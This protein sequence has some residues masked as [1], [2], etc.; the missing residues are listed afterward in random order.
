MFWTPPFRPSTPCTKR[1]PFDF[2]ISLGDACN[3]TQYNE[4]R[5]YLD[6]IDGKVI[7]PSSGANLGAT[8]VDYQK[9][10]KAAGLNPAIPWYQAMGNH[11]H[12]FIGSV[13]VDADPSLQLRQSYTSNKIW[14]AGDVVKPNSGNFPCIFDTTASIKEQTFYMGVLDGS[15]PYGNVK[16]AGP[17][18]TMGASPSGC[19]GPQSAVALA[20]RM[21]SGVLQHLVVSGGPRPQSGRLF[22]G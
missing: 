10:F 20:L 15:T 7:T 1:V 2:G 5:W 12:F 9:P 19:R 13:P 22:H 8:T 3:S 6:V 18:A 17:V 4:L 14:A 11:D 16:G 21:D